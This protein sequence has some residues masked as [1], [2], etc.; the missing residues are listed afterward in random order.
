MEPVEPPLDPPLYMQV[1]MIIYVCSYA[2]LYHL[3][4]CITGNVRRRCIM[5]ELW[6]EFIECFREETRMLFDQVN[7]YCY[8]C[9]YK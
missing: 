6:E 3:L 2:C 5:D 4:V 8:C 1:Y 7:E 9:I